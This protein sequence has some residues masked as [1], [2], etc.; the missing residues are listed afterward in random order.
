MKLCHDTGSIRSDSESLESTLATVSL[1]LHEVSNRLI[2]LLLLTG[3][4]V[5]STGATHDPAEQYH[6]LAGL[7]LIFEHILLDRNST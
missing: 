6:V 4:N 3:M 5:S 7:K 1:L 2:E